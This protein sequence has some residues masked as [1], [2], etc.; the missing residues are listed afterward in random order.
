[1]RHLFY[2]DQKYTTVLRGIDEPVWRRIDQLA[3]KER[4]SRNAMILCLLDRLLEIPPEKPRG[5]LCILCINSDHQNC[6]H[7]KPN[8]DYKSKGE[9]VDCGCE[10]RD[11]K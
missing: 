5:V 2:M 7:G 1:M 9:I 8:P 6:A 11:K 10:C 4:R 3:K